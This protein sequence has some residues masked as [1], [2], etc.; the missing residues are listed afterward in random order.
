[1]SS[2]L[3]CGHLAELRD[4]CDPADGEY[5]DTCFVC[6]WRSPERLRKDLD[7][8]TRLA[9]LFRSRLAVFEAHNRK[10]EE[11]ATRAIAT[12]K[13]AVAATKRAEIALRE[14]ERKAQ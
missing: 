9:E 12:A 8:Q 6:D 2:V 10:L 13:I 4:A 11:V 1:M 14:A 7:S 3:P 5:L